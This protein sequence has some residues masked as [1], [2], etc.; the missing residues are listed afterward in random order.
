M[1]DEVVH[2]FPEQLADILISQDPQA[3]LIGKGAFPLKI[4]AVDRLGRG[5]QEQSHLRFRCLE[6]FIRLLM[7]DDPPQILRDRIDQLPF[8]LE[9]RSITVAGHIV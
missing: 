8:L 5:I 3:G 9:K 7:V 6:L 4:D 2:V 1:M